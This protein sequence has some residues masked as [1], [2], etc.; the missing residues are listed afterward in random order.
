MP[1]FVANNK[2]LAELL[3]FKLS[4]KMADAVFWYQVPLGARAKVR[5]DFNC[6]YLLEDIKFEC[7]IYRGCTM[8]HELL[9]HVIIFHF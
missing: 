7:E 1:Q 2:I 9:S 3:T 8:A 6:L 5:V 4:Y